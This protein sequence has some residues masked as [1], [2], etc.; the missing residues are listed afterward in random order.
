VSSSPSLRPIYLAVDGSVSIG[1]VEDVRTHLVAQLVAGL[2]EHR[3]EASVRLSVMEFA[4]EPR[5]AAALDTPRNIPIPI[6]RPTRAGTSFARL[7]QSLRQH[8]S[9][10][11]EQLQADGYDVRR[12][13]VC[14]LTD[15]RATSDWQAD[16]DDLVAYDQELNLGFAGRPRIMAIGVGDYDA[17]SLAEMVVPS[18][19]KRVLSADDQD[20]IRLAVE[21]LLITGETLPPMRPVESDDWL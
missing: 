17:L 15:G 8:I 21:M 13:S 5:T 9:R 3:L 7:F 14:L 2:A 16:H 11:L 20:C 4:G 10:D 18:T 1:P 12:P 6:L 19:R